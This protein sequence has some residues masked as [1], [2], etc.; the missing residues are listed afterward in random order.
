MYI[1][2]PD[3]HMS[4]RS[5]LHPRT[6]HTTSPVI[7]LSR[8]LKVSQGSCR[9]WKRSACNFHHI[10]TKLAGSDDTVGGADKDIHKYLYS[11]PL[12]PL[13]CRAFT[14]ENVLI[15]ECILSSTQ[16]EHESA[17]TSGHVHPPLE[18]H[19]TQTAR[20]RAVLG[21]SPRLSLDVGVFC[22]SP[23]MYANEGYEVL[24]SSDF[25]II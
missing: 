12:T 23:P 2:H 16:H 6:A 14:K 20:K 9:V 25:A 10:W 8:S 15:S 17:L 5:G 19:G 21:K 3:M 13:A 4:T 11:V 1:W 22:E 7:Y 18:L 24:D